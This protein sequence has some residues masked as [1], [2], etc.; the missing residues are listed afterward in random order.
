MPRCEVS[1]ASATLKPSA[2]EVAAEGEG[3][4]PV[5]GRRQPGIGLAQ[6]VG[7]DMGGRVDRARKGAAWRRGRSRRAGR[8]V[9]SIA[10]V[11]RQERVPS[12]RHSSLSPCLTAAQLESKAIRTFQ[13][14]VD[15]ERIQISSIDQAGRSRS[16]GR[17]GP[18]LADG[19]CQGARRDGAAKRARAGHDDH[20]HRPG[21]RR[22]E[23]DGVARP[24]RL[25]A[26]EAPKRATGSHGHATSSAMSTTAAPQIC[27]RRGRASSAWSSP[28]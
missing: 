14:H 5:D 21:G 8:R 9:V 25:A 28:T 27:A 24:A 18:A 26:G 4:V 7:D 13:S 20:R 10:A 22:V 6:R 3:G 1:I 17:T 15:L 11:G 2:P 23:V 12:S 19:T 16:E